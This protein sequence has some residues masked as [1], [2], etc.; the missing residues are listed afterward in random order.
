MTISM[1]DQVAA[2]AALT[3]AGAQAD[4]AG[5]SALTGRRKLITGSAA[6]AGMAALGGLGFPAIIHAQSDKIKI[7][8]L[9]PRTGCLGAL[10]EYSVMALSW[11]PAM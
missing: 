5:Q 11:P 6:M 9:T 4:F 1:K 10:G 3:P 7:G 2:T 8:H